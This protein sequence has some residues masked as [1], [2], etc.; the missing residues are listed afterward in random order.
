MAD[1][2]GRAE[3]PVALRSHIEMSSAQDG[4]LEA[5]GR[6]LVVS[7]KQVWKGCWSLSFSPH[8][9]AELTAPL[10]GRSAAPALPFTL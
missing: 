7:G 2:T 6:A 8:S 4:D 9:R 10:Q 1:G 3:V 5:E